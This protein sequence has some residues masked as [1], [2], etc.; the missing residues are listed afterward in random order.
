MSPKAH[1]VRTGLRRGWTE[2]VLSVRSPQDQGFYVF[3]AAIVL[4]YLFF[5]RDSDVAGTSL[6]HAAV[7]L[8]SILGAMVTFSLIIGPAY[9]LAMDREDGT[10]LRARALPHGILGYVS[11]QVLTHSLA[12][13]PSFAV[14]LLPSV[15]LFEGV[16]QGGPGGWLTMVW[17]IGLGLLAA[18]PIGIIIGSLAPGVQKV[19]TW[20]MLPVLVLFGIS[21][22]FS[23]LQSLWG[24]V[25]V[26]AQVFPMY[27][28]G[29]GMRSAFLPDAAAAIEIGGS[30]RTLET[31]AVLGAW[32][33]A[34]LLLAPVV[35]RRMARRQSGS[36]VEAARHEAV[37]WVR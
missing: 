15:V 22:I 17:V 21:G 6:S 10:L 5:N 24:W 36:Q 4:L 9:Q 29:L 23:P 25:Q 16:M 20:G 1:A 14:I 34:G 18:M 3:S 2:F 37:Q 13:I 27:W 12:L 30:W 28:L 33:V 26:V 8:P 31:V 11:G 19:G 35:L 7:T 32:A